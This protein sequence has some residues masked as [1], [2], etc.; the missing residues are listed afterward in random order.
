MKF[1]QA[2]RFEA[3]K[4]SQMWEIEKMSLRSQADFEREEGD[5]QQ[6]LGSIDKKLLALEKE[7]DAGRFSSDELAYT[8]AVNYWTAQ[9]DF[10]ETG[11]KCP[12]IPW[13]QHPSQ[14]QEPGAVS[15]RG[16]VEAKAQGQDFGVSPYW[17]EFKDAPEGSPEK[18]IYDS[19]LRSTTQEY[20]TGTR[21]THLDPTFMR[22][23]PKDVAMEILA[24]Q[25]IFI[26][27]PEEL[28][29]FLQGLESE[30]PANTGVQV[31]P[32]SQETPR[33][34]ST[35]RTLDTVTAQSILNEAG[36]NKERAR[37]IARQRGY[38]F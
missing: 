10:V 33:G 17:M 22:K 29:S 1:Q 13:Y 4:R 15:A 28:D 31:P 18:A 12:S 3:E 20:R 37:E 25:E 38:S 6:R 9:K 35:P 30:A 14:F 16:A 26:D 7:K 24:S 36:G 19:Q 21:P 27:S 11:T 5:R 34:G 32:K 8:N 23:L 2:S